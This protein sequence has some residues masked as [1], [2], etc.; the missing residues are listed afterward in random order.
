M[1]KIEYVSNAN[2][3]HKAWTNEEQDFE[4]YSRSSFYFRFIGCVPYSAE[5]KGCL[6]SEYESS[7]SGLSRG[8]KR[9]LVLIVAISCAVAAGCLCLAWLI[10]R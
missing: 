2:F 8:E 6:M 7:E 4:S 9:R 1:K 3:F 5:W 10:G